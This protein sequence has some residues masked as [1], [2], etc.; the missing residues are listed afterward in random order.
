MHQIIQL[1][2]F[3]VEL[4][5]TDFADLIKEFPYENRAKMCFMG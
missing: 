3:Q 2:K 4:K 5:I 1:L